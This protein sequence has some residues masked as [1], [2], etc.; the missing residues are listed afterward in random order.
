M[1]WIYGDLLDVHCKCGLDYS[2]HHHSVCPSCFTWPPSLSVQAAIADSVKVREREA[3][4][5][6][7]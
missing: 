6:G 4:K 1:A 5:G 2:L 3:L 7:H